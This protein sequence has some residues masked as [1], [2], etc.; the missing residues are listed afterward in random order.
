MFINRGMDKKDL[1]HVHNEILVI[2]NNEMMQFVANM[3]GP[4][5]YHTK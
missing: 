2:K 1:V 5:N 4:R 3:D